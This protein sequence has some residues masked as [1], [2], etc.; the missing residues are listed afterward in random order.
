[1]ECFTLFIL[2]RL[3]DFTILMPL[4]AAA[5]NDTDKFP[6][7]KGISILNFKF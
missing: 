1:M 7:P 5:N 2:R 3:W 6:F 4:E